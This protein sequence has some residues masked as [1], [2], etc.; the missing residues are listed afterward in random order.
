MK[1]KYSLPFII[2]SITG[3]LSAKLVDDQSYYISTYDTKFVYS[4]EKLYYY[5]YP[6]SKRFNLGFHNFTMK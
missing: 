6:Y 3:L 5:Y 4:I 2:R 1:I